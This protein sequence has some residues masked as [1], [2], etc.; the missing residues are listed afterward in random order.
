MIMTKMFLTRRVNIHWYYVR[1]RVKDMFFSKVQN[2]IYGKFLKHYSDVGEITYYKSPS[3]IKQ[4]NY[5]QLIKEL[6][7]NRFD[8]DETKDKAIKKDD[9]Q[10]QFRNAGE[11]NQHS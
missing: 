6:W 5:K 9:W 1:S 7:D 2:R 11:A 3:N 10:H 4:V 8:E